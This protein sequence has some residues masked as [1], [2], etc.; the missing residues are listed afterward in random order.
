MGFHPNRFTINNIFI[1]RQILEKCYKCNNE[2][3]DIFVDYSR[4][5]DSIHRNK[6]IECLNKYEIP[7]KLI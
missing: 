2:L 3:H 1:V 7:Q 6:I 4:A 5:F